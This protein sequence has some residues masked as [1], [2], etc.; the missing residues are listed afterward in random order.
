MRD[1]RARPV[2]AGQKTSFAIV[3]SVHYEQWAKLLDAENPDAVFTQ[4]PIDNHIDHRATAMLSYGAWVDSKKK[5]CLYY[6]EVTNGGDTLQFSPTHYD[7]IT[8]TEPQNVRPAMRTLM[9]H[10]MVSTKYKIRL[11]TSE[12]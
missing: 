9:R 4:W 1:L 6:Y 7:N 5:F 2:W 10:L 8:E 11:P 12:E 3:D